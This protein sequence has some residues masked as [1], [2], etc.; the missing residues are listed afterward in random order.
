MGY[1]RGFIHGAVA[2]AVIGVLIAP[3]EGERTRA[4]IRSFGRAARGGIDTA[5]RTAKH[6]APV[7]AGAA[8]LARR[9]QHEDLEPARGGSAENGHR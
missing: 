4:Q 1:I 2:G 5:Q 7:V 9:H 8:S 3:H 6:M